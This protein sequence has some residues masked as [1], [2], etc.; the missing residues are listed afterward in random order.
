M[1]L[2]L[3]VR[4]VLRISRLSCVTKRSLNY[5]LSA[6]KGDPTLASPM[7]SCTKSLRIAT[8]KCVERSGPESSII[9]DKRFVQLPSFTVNAYFINNFF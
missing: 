7:Y 8:R 2:S 1:Q 3:T 6:R 5:T 4:D 9:L